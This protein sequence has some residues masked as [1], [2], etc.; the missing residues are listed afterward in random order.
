MIVLKATQA[1]FELIDTKLSHQDLL[2]F[3]QDANNDW[4]VNVE[5]RTNLRF[6]EIVVDD[7][8]TSKTVM[9]VLNELVEIT[10][11]P[12]LGL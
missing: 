10:Y 5:N 1:Q 11:I 8:G 3:V 9:Q 4:V 6:N 2:R 7:S 12:S